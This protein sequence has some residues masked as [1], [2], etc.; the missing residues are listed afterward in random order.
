MYAN[1]AK[2]DK[3][4]KY[5]KQRYDL[6][7]PKLPTSTAAR[8]ARCRQEVEYSTSDGMARMSQLLASPI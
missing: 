2:L 8:L 5:D 4:Y 6:T 1:T 3:L 7:V